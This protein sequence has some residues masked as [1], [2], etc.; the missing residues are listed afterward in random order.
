MLLSVWANSFL[1]VWEFLNFMP[2]RLACASVRLEQLPTSKYFFWRGLH[3]STSRLLYLRS[4]KSPEQHTSVR[5]GIC[6]DTKSSTVY[7]Q[8]FSYQ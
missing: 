1:P 5:T 6:M 3:A 7:D 2:R 4:A 8:S